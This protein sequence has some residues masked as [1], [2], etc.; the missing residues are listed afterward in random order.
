VPISGS[1]ALASIDLPIGK[2]FPVILRTIMLCLPMVLVVTS[3]K[4]AVEFEPLQALLVFTVS[5]AIIY[6]LVLW[7]GEYR[8]ILNNLPKKSVRKPSL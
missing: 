1:K 7:Y 2:V 8:F 4:L 5:G 6:A 3:L